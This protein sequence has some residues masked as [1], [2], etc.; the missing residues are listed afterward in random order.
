MGVVSQDF[1]DAL[2]AHGVDPAEV[3]AWCYDQW[4][5]EYE[6]VL[7]STEEVHPDGSVSTVARP[8]GER[9]EVLAAGDRF[10]LRPE[11]CLFLN[12]ALERRERSKMQSLLDDIA[13][14]LAALEE[15]P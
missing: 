2:I 9:Q 1:R 8:T 3:A 7:E 10:G 13:T 14:R 12:A 4:Q 6:D 11:Q 15:R 5:A